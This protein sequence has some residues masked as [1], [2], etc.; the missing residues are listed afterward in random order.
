MQFYLIKIRYK[1][2]AFKFFP[3]TSQN[4]RL[5][6]RNFKKKSGKKINH[7]RWSENVYV[8]LRNSVFSKD[9]KFEE[10]LLINVD[11]LE[12]LVDKHIRGNKKS[13]L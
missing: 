6:S 12:I 5:C 4:I 10:I 2:I 13:E 7:R 8:T 3:I 1:F 9:V 11:L